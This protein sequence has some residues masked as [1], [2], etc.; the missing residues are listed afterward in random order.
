VAIAVFSGA[1]ETPFADGGAWRRYRI[2]LWKTTS[3]GSKPLPPPPP[4]A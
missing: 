1:E 3:D 4:A 2:N